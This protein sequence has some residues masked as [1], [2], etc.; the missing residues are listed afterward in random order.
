MVAFNKFFTTVFLAIAYASVSNA[1]PWAQ[2]SKYATHSRR[3]LDNGLQLELYHPESTYTTFGEGLELGANMRGG[4]LKSRTVGFVRQRLGIDEKSVTFKTGYSSESGAYGYARQYHDGI[5]FANAVANVAFN[6]NKVIAFGSSFVKPKKVAPK[7]PTISLET[8][9]SSAERTL[10]GKHNGQ[11]PSIEYFVKADGTAALSHVIQIQNDEAFT[12]YEAFVDAHT[13]ELLSVTDF[14]NK[15]TYH[16]LPITKMTVVEGLETLENPHHKDASPKGWHDD[17]TKVHNATIGNNVVAFKGSQSA[18]TAASG[19][20]AFVYNFD[21][22]AE[23]TDGTNLEV[24]RTNAFYMLNMIHDISYIYGF[25]QEAYNFEHS[26]GDKDSKGSGDRVLMSVQDRGGMNNAAFATP[27]DGQSGKCY[28]YLWNMSKLKRDGSLENDVIVHEM[29]H[30]ITNRMTGGGTGRCLQTS[31]AGGMG[32]GWGDAFANWSEQKDATIKDFRLG[33]Y[34][35]KEEG[36]RDYPYSTD[37]AKNPLKYSD[38]KK[39]RGVHDIGVVWANMLHN[40]YAAL[41]GEYGFADPKIAHYDASGKEG[42]VIYMNLFIKALPIQPCN[43]TFAQARDAWLQAD[44]VNYKGIHKCT[45]WKAFASRG[46][47]VKADKYVDDFS[48]PEECQAPPTQEPE[49]P[50]TETPETETPETETPE[51]ETPENPETP[52]EST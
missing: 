11:T 27:P 12:W 39:R 15:A 8:A 3:E 34:V 51:V 10:N 14:V 28:M 20:D 16:V 7:K 33:T 40:V 18:T 35:Y 44:E 23:P 6:G 31:E 49:T 25:T 5:P 21:I 19:E 17:G 2:H 24:A 48:V 4:D 37:S 13:G 22:T 32:E 41:V 50:E 9:I 43:P 42:N 1:A 52:E 26:H 38:V 45:V 36:I 46:L 30:G 29:T 47:G